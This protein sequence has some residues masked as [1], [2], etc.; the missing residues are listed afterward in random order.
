M[1]E[2]KKMK[3]EGDI[4]DVLRAIMREAKSGNVEAERLLLEHIYNL[5]K[6]ISEYID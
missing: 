6:I 2:K 5:H 4:P 1:K 3:D